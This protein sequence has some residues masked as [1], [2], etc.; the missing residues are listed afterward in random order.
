VLRVQRAATGTGPQ[1]EETESKL[2]SSN[3]CRVNR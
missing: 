3:I 2:R 1:S